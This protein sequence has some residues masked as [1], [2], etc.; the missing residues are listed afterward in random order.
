MGSWSKSKEKVP[1][2]LQSERLERGEE[3]ERLVEEVRIKVHVNELDRREFRGERP[4]GVHFIN[5][6]K[7]VKIIKLRKG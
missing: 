4:Q 1:D 2:G 5:S 3:V 6:K 7:S